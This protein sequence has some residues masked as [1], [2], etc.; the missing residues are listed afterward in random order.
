M[1]RRA[2]IG[3]EVVD[4]QNALLRGR[5]PLVALIRRCPLPST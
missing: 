5:I 4:Q 2:H 1:R 3:Q